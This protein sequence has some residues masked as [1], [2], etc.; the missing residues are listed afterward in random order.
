MLF[1]GELAA[2]Q[3]SALFN[4]IS[5]TE[6]TNTREVCSLQILYNYRIFNIE[7]ENACSDPL[8]IRNAE[9]YF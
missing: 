9:A 5:C 3:H 7:I 1:E 2:L 4:E 8:L 6:A